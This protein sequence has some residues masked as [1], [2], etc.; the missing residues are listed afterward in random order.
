MK[1]KA[2]RRSPDPWRGPWLFLMR[3]KPYKSVNSKKAVKFNST[4]P[5]LPQ[6]V[7]DRD[8]EDVERHALEHGDSEWYTGSTRWTWSW[9]WNELGA[10]GN[11]QTRSLCELGGI[12][13]RKSFGEDWGSGTP[14]TRRTSWRSACDSEIPERETK[15]ARFSPPTSP[16]SGSALFPPHYAGGIQEAHY[17]DDIDWEND[18][19]DD[20][21]EELDEL[22]YILDFD[23][24]EEFTDEKKPPTLTEEEM[25]VVEA[26]AGET[27]ID[28]LFEIQVIADP[29][30]EELETGAILSTRSVFDWRWRNGKWTRRCRLVAREFKGYSRGNQETFAPTSTTMLN[31]LL[32]ALHLC[33]GYFLSFLDVKNAFL[34]VLQQ[35]T[36]LV[37]VPSWWKPSEIPQDGSPRYWSLKKCLPGQRNAAS[38]WYS[39]LRGHLEELGFSALE[40]APAMFRHENRSLV[41]CAHVDDLAVA[42]TKED[43]TWCLDALRSKFEISGGEIHPGVLTDPHNPLLFLK[44]RHNF[45]KQGVILKTHERYIPSLLKLYGLEN[46]RSKPTPDGSV[47]K[48]DGGEALADADKKRFRSALGTLL[49]ICQDRPDIQHSVKNLSQSMT[50]PTR[51]AERALKHLLL[52]LSGTSDFG[53]L[54]PYA[55]TYWSKKSFMFDE[56][57]KVT[58]DGTSF[59]EVYCDADWGGDQ[60]SDARR[61]HSVSSVII[62]VNNIMVQSWSRSQKSIALSSCESEFLSLIGGCAEGLHVKKVWEFLSRKPVEL[63][64]YTDSSS[65]LALTQRLG[66]GRV[67]HLDAKMLWIQSE[68]KK[69]SIIVE[70]VSTVFNPADLNTKK[71]NKL[72]RDFVMYLAGLVKPGGKD[73]EHVE[74]GKEAYEL[75]L[76]KKALEQDLKQVRRIMLKNLSGNGSSLMNSNLGAAL[77]VLAIRPVNGNETLDEVTVKVIGYADAL[78]Q[79]WCLI[80]ALM[81]FCFVLGLL[82]GVFHGQVRAWL[83]RKVRHW[84]RELMDWWQLNVRREPLVAGDR[85]NTHEQSDGVYGDLAGGLDRF[86]RLGRAMEGTGS[87]VDW[88]PISGEVRNFRIL[89]NESDAESDET[90]FQYNRDDNS[91]AR[92]ARPNRH[93]RREMEAHAM[94]DVDHD[95]DENEDMNGIWRQMVQFGD[96]V[97]TFAKYIN[98]LRF[99]VFDFGPERPKR[100]LQGFGYQS[101]EVEIPTAPIGNYGMWTH[102][103]TIEQY[104]PRVMARR[105]QRI[106]ARNLFSP[107]L[108]TQMMQMKLMQLHDG[109]PD[110]TWDHILTWDNWDRGAWAYFCR[111]VNGDYDDNFE[112][113]MTDWENADP[114]NWPFYHDWEPLA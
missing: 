79:V 43:I 76:H 53:V 21:E 57:E 72:R 106:R 68:V 87:I 19:L 40:V 28:R 2:I 54:L 58:N 25:V 46:R 74:V 71:L 111:L 92:K 10:K 44:R 33:F 6:I 18:M 31:R 42:G 86:S 81:A 62:Y 65:C 85:R 102:E 26:A 88:D 109:H 36:V 24:N 55:T 75:Y 39:F 114:D 59:I 47:V 91:Y 51:D 11:T 83:Q 77:A 48:L 70:K 15:T 61:R 73:G 98:G 93:E 16:T 84:W 14:D 34:L 7:E 22:D 108:T 29:T 100:V 112:Q 20:L 52:Y 37:Q 30:V 78:Q 89:Q 13:T 104:M 41:L 95:F 32:L 64:A 103:P 101:A 49:Y 110:M 60:S 82:V 23:D 90:Y 105:C 17:V 1:G 9:Q 5:V 56:V 107:M 45:T 50:S 113:A 27:E 80:L 94:R 99:T 96:E 35:E 69:G 8:A 38:R 3:D 4:P 97:P 12:G 66:V 67:K 63:K